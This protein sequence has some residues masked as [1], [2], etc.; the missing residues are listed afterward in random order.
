MDRYMELPK[1]DP[2][3]LNRRKVTVRQQ[4]T[5]E[6]EEMKKLYQTMNRD[7]MQMIAQQAMT[8][9]NDSDLLKLD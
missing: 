7:E 1:E 4:K 6:P 8:N 9:K 3:P 2:S 5:I